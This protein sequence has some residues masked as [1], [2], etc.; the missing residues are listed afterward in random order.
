MITILD[1]RADHL[2]A[3]EAAPVAAGPAEQA[4]ER[5]IFRHRDFHRS[6]PRSVS[7]L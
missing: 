6:L 2:S 7:C 3:V 1:L 4:A 5:R